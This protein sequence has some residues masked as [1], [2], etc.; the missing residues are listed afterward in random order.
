M[1]ILTPKGQE[2]LRQEKKA[3][4]LFQ[5]NFRGFDF[6]ETPKDKPAD[7][8]GLIAKDSTLLAGVEVKCRNMTAHDL[9]NRY[10]R[11][12]LVTADKLDRGVRTCKSLGIDF[13]GF[14]Y[15]VPDNMLM[16]VPIWSYRDGWLADVELDYTETQATVNGGTAIRVNA[17][18]DTSKAKI[19]A[20]L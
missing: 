13:R 10:K 19:V 20:D 6:V 3:I 16:I 9:A 4:R 15:L 14:L 12:W 7:I 17:Y 8:D 1:D 18:I 5:E 11:R 2:T